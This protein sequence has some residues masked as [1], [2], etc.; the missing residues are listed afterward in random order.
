MIQAGWL[1]KHRNPEEAPD[2]PA[3]GRGYSTLQH[4][5]RIELLESGSDGDSNGDAPVLLYVEQVR[6]F[7][8]I[9]SRSS[10]S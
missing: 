10:H 1:L 9:P 2:L 3:F 8:G 6:L 7:G 4:G 5:L